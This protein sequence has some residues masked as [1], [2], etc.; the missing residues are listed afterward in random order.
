MLGT[1]ASVTKRIGP[2]RHAI[3]IEFMTF[4]VQALVSL[5]GTYSPINTTLIVNIDAPAFSG[6]ILILGGK[7]PNRAVFRKQLTL[8]GLRSELANDL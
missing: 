2:Q 5:I 7:G 4:D 3:L 1:R 8:L 6:R